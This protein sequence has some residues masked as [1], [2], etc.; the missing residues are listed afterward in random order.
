MLTVLFLC[1][2]YSA[3]TLCRESGLGESFFDFIGLPSNEPRPSANLYRDYR[4]RLALKHQSSFQKARF[5]RPLTETA[6]PPL[7]LVKFEK[8]KNSSILRQAAL[9]PWVT[10][11]YFAEA[12]IDF[13][14]LLTWERGVTTDRIEHKLPYTLENAWLI[15]QGGISLH[16][17]DFRP[18]RL[19]R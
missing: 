6:A 3:T 2:V 9:D 18:Q 4:F 5:I 17:H 14:V 16:R 11:A 13:P 7:Q 19:S 8:T 1:G 15:D 10:R 12:F